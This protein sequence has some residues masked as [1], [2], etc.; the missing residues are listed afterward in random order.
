MTDLKLISLEDINQAQKRIAPYIRNTPSVPFDYLNRKLNKEI[1]L[2]CE[3]FQKTGSFKF[4][5]AANCVLAQ[6]AQA[7]KAGVVAA[8]AG[9]HAQGVA[10]ICYTLGIPATIVMPIATPGIKVQNTQNWGAT[11]ELVGNFYDESYE[12]A[13]KLCKERGSLF[14]HPFKDPL[15]QAGQGT[16]GLELLGE[17]LNKDTQAVIISVGGGGLITGI[18]TVLRALNPK[19]KIYGVTAQSAPAAFKAVKENHPTE[20][21]VDFTLAEGVATKRTEQVMLENISRNVDDIFSLSEESIAHAISVLAEHGKMVVE[22]AGALPIAAMLEGLVPEKKVTAV[23][24]GGNID[25]PALSAVFRRGLVE[26]GRLVRL[27]ITIW[28]R[29]GA[30]HGITQVFAEK[31][32]NVLEIHHQRGALH[33]K[34]GQAAIEA[35]IETRGEE[36]TG[37]IINAL[38]SRGFHVERNS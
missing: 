20:E 14:I 27:N 26:Q 17:P 4:R 37:E 30:L 10:S 35:E 19:I 28:D 23:L 38:T 1:I 24:C 15:V 25:L 34:M 16:L 8:S 18:G 13:M 31:R 33:H 21:P 22:G 3:I 12:H 32:A 2:K 5:G 9:N 7:K 29:P 36:H 11:V 6:M